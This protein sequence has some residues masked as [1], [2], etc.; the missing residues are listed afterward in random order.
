MNRQECSTGKSGPHNVVLALINS[1]FLSIE[2]PQFLLASK[3]LP[4]LQTDF[5]NI[6]FVD[7]AE[8]LVQWQV[9]LSKTERKTITYSGVKALAFHALI[10]STAY[11]PKALPGMIPKQN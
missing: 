1:S 5:Y 8:K 7:L 6:Y 10:P 11:S 2:V 3:T 4:C 9:V